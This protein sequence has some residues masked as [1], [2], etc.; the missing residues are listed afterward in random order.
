[1]D[2]TVLKLENLSKSFFTLD[3]EIEVIKDLN[4]ELKEGEKIAIVGPSGCGKSTILNLIS[5][6]IK[7]DN[8][9]IKA[10]GDVGYMFQKDNLLDWRT[11]YKNITIGLEIKGKISKKQKE[12]ID[13]LLIKYGLYEF[14]NNYPHELSGGMR[15]RVA[16]IRT[17]VLNP[18]ILLLDEP[19]S[20]LDAQTKI[21]VNED[22]YDIVT[23]ENKSVILVTHDIAEAIA[24][25]DKVIVLTNRPS[26]IKKT[27][28]I[29]FN[30]LGKRTP[31]GARKHIL[32]K[33]YFDKIWGDLDGFK[34]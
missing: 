6:L 19:F 14:K 11:I 1:M 16:L 4:L 24:F 26:T 21:A 8:G 27:Y 18:T 25:C 22:V 17:L 2:K 30:N 13:D 3:G 23:K 32:F 12:T 34:N 7:A 20:A 28:E 31:L 33:D 15:Q 29:V 10:F 9:E 5:N